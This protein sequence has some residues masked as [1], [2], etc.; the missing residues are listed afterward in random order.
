MRSFPEAALVSFTQD[1]IDMQ[2]IV[3]V[4]KGALDGG[5]TFQVNDGFNYGS[6]HEFTVTANVVTISLVAKYEIMV[7]LSLYYNVFHL[8]R[9]KSYLK[10][11]SYLVTSCL[12][13]QGY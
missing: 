13:K 6:K 12:I 5:F 4:Q 9:S 11:L 1:M 8:S 3:F 2:Q 7:S 10:S